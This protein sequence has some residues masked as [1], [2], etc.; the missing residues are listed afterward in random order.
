MR[1]VSLL[2]PSPLLLS[3]SLSP[4]PKGNEPGT[5]LIIPQHAQRFI[6]FGLRCWISPY[7]WCL[8]S[9]SLLL[10]IRP[11]VSLQHQP[12]LFFSFF[13]LLFAAPLSFLSPA[14]ATASAVRPFANFCTGWPNKERPF[15]WA[16]RGPLRADSF[17]RDSSSCRDG[18]W[19]DLANHS[20]LD[21]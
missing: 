16:V 7:G 15:E 11:F 10:S 4:P 5:L 6:I 20:I 9:L 1:F 14:F 18:G 8:P 12:L 2:R 19:D 17:V 13:L 21:R 3:L